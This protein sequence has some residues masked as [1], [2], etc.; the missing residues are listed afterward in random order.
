MADFVHARAEDELRGGALERLGTSST[1]VM[2]Y[3][4]RNWPIYDNVATIRS[5]RS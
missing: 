2:E 1:T 5:P 3:L 4:Q